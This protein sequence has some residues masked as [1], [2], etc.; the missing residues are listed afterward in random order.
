MAYLNG[1][2][3]LRANSRYV[4]GRGYLLAGGIAYSALFS[5]AGSLT[6]ALTFLAA[7]IGSNRE[8]FDSFIEKTNSVLPGVLQTAENPNGLL[9]PEDLIVE[10]PFN[11]VTLI[12]LLIVLWSALSLM[13]GLRLAIWNM[14]GIASLPMVF[15]SQKIRDLGAFL[16]LGVSVVISTVIAGGA[17][18]FADQIFEFLNLPG[19]WARILLMGLTFLVGVFV[20]TLVFIFI[21]VVLAGIKAPRRDLWL[22]SLLAGVL[23]SVVRGLGT[24]AVSSVADNPLLAPFAAIVTILLWV[25][26]IARITLNAAAFIANPPEALVLN[27]DYFPH[28]NDAPNYVTKSD[29]RTLAWAHDP[30]TGVVL[31]DLRA[32]FMRKVN[33]EVAAG[34][35]ELEAEYRQIAQKQAQAEKE[36]IQIAEKTAR[37]AEEIKSA[38]RKAK[39]EARKA[40]QTQQAGFDPYNYAVP[41]AG[42]WRSEK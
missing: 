11:I 19:Q 37:E 21:F 29:L 39:W 36:R 2:R 25:N 6:I 22:G 38:E 12:S 17:S 3:L 42:I 9:N 15:I 20:D 35:L 40:A 7:A 10:N 24:S 4:N 26:L 5:I 31:P 1:T 23:S 33:Q 34:A 13:S 8:I 27:N 14:F 41:S 28:A 30:I 18:I 16:V 32:G